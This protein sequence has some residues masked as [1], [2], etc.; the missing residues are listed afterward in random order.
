[1]PREGKMKQCNIKSLKKKLL[2]DFNIDDTRNSL[3]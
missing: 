2:C 1:M 3:L